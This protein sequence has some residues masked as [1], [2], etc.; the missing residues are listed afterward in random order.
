MDLSQLISRVLD[1]EGP[2]RA[3]DDSIA[4]ALG[5][6]KRFETVGD[7]A[8]DRS[9]QV[10]Q[11]LWLVPSGEVKEVPAYTKGAQEAYDLVLEVAPEP[12][13]ALVVDRNGARAMIEGEPAMHAK[14]PAI[15]LC[16]AALGHLKFTGRP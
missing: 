5:W 15:A 12:A 3:V 1:L 4:E 14:T 9:R 8:S 10:Q 6:S 11:K 16:A 13:C 7:V 2:S